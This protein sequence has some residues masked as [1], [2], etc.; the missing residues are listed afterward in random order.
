MGERGRRYVNNDFMVCDA[1]E[2][3]VSTV[4]KR[5]GMILK[6]AVRMDSSCKE[7]PSIQDFEKAMPLMHAKL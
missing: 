4:R 7:F 6:D 3:V 1:L 5:G 2:W